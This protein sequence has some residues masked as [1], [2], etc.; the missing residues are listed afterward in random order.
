M[1]TIVC[2]ADFVSQGDVFTYKYA[3]QARKPVIPPRGDGRW[4]KLPAAQRG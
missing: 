3:T 1:Y 4:V 2:Q